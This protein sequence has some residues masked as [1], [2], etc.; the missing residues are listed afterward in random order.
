MQ[1]IDIRQISFNPTFTFTYSGVLSPEVTG[2]R[3]YN[4]TGA[5][6]K[7]AYVRASLGSPATGRSVFVDVLKNNE[8]IF[9]PYLGLTL[10][11]PEGAHSAQLAPD[12]LYS[13]EDNPV[14]WAAGEYLTV[15]ILRIGSDF[16]GE[17]LTIN[18]VVSE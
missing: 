1:F 18:V 3:L 9:G 14:V 13:K 2:A 7:L 6:R 16:P 8:S 15:S 11:I 5:S 17:D 10:E 4:D 12:T